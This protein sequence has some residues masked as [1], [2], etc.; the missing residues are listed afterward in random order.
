MQNK[1]TRSTVLAA[2]AALALAGGG[3]ANAAEGSSGSLSGSS[4][5]SGSSTGSSATPGTPYEFENWDTCQLDLVYNPVTDLGTC[6]TVIIRD[7][8]MRIGNLDVAVPDGS[9]M[10][11]GGVSQDA[12]DPTI[13]TFVPAADDGKFGV[14]ANPITVPGGAFGAASAENFG[15]TAIQ[16]TVEAVALP[17]VDP[18]NLA[19][20]LPVRMKLSNPLL[21]DNCYIGSAA[22]PIN[23]SLD[24]VEAGTAEWISTNGP[25]VPGGV[26]PQATHEAADFAVPGATGCGPLGS[27]NWAVNLRAGLPSAGTGN[28]LSTTS[29]VY[30]VAGWELLEP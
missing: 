27:L 30:N 14:Y 21:G 15:P 4:G 12:D 23:L 18:Y 24:L 22:N 1:T 6:M 16:A 26:W 13:Q 8:D 17:A 3:V 28:S 19:V 10:I 25:D 7:G 9:L 29:A 20:Q 2:V 11:A 5:S